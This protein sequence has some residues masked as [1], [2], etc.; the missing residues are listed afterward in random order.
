LGSG[1]LWSGE[2]YLILDTRESGKTDKPGHY[3]GVVLSTQALARKSGF[4]YLEGNTNIWIDEEPEQKL[5]YTGLE[6]YFQGAWYYVKTAN[7]A[8][9]ESLNKKGLLG[10][11]LLARTLRTRACQYR[12]HPEGIPFSRSI[13]VVSH[14]GEFDEIE[15][16]YSSVAF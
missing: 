8:A 2:P 14:H 12:F 3:V 6:D 13:R 10:S 15:C 9:T 4:A 7:R 11:S 1:I 5:E 16:N